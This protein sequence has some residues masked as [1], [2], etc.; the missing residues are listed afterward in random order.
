M[1]EREQEVLESIP[2]VTWRG[3]LRELLL[4]HPGAWV[5]EFGLDRVA[6]I[7]GTKVR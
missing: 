2:S 5:G 7:R 3:K 4:R 6:F 1:T